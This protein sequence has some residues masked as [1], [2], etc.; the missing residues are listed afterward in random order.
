[1]QTSCTLKV[2]D[3]VVVAPLLSR[4]LELQ[5]LVLMMQQVQA[6]SEFLKLLA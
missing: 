3:K 5:D 2:R 4:Q 1:M 6:Q